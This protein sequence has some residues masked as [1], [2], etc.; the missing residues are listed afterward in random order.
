MLAIVRAKIHALTMAATVV[1]VIASEKKSA[2]VRTVC[3]ETN[4]ARVV[5]MTLIDPHLAA[6]VQPQAVTAARD[7]NTPQAEIAHAS[8]G[9]NVH[10]VLFRIASSDNDLRIFRRNN[11]NRCLRR[12]AHTDVPHAIH[13]VSARSDL[14]PISR[15]QSRHRLHQCIAIR[16]RVLDYPCR[17]NG[18]PTRI[19]ASLGKT[20]GESSER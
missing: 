16:L 15:L 14:K 19:V 3:A 2:C 11:P 10:H 5:D 8:L 12:A 18:C 20:F 7:F 1:V 17:R 4:F 13:G 6:L 9:A